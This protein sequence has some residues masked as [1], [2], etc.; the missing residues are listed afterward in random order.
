MLCLYGEKAISA[1]ISFSWVANTETDLAG[2]EL[3]YGTTAT[4]ISDCI[5]VGNVT[6][7]TIPDL[8][9]DTRY[10]FIVKA[11]NTDGVTS[12][13]SRMLSSV[14]KSTEDTINTFF[15]T[16]STNNT[17][18]SESALNATDYGLPQQGNIPLIGDVDNDGFKNIIIFNEITGDWYKYNYATNSYGIWLSGFGQNSTN[19]FLADVDNN[20]YLDP[21]VFFDIPGLEGNWYVAT[22]SGGSVT[23]SAILHVNCCVNSQNHLT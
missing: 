20:G 19:Q 18:G 5:D 14:V 3:C 16:Y 9:S 21:V 1:E 22:N 13:N 7:F 10:F 23:M 6:L 8:V 4:N 12:D 11:Y 17:F 15:T 2:Y